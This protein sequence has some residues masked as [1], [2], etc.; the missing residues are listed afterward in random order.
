LPENRR[1]GAVVTEPTLATLSE[2]ERKALQRKTLRTLMVSQTMGSAGVSVAVS[3]GGR[4]VSQITGGSR[5]GGTS[6]AAVTFGG[7]LA[8]LALSGLM[9]QRGRRP[10]LTAGYILS[11]LGG[12]VVVLGIEQNSL[13]IF[14]FG[15]LF[16]GVGQGTNL[17]ARYAAADLTLPT[18]RAQAMSLLM[19]GS[20]FGA[21]LSLVLIE[22]LRTV[23][24]RVGLQ[25]FSGPYLFAVVLLIIALLNTGLRLY[26]DPLKVAGGVSPSAKRFQVPN[27]RHAVGVVRQSRLATLGLT[28][29]IVS[30]TAMVAVMTMTPIH[31]KEHGHDKVSSLV[32]ALHVVGMYGFAPI[33]GRMSDRWG[34]LQV[35]LAGAAVMVAATITSAAAG[36]RPSVLFIGLFLLG[37][38]WSGAMISGTALVT[39]NVPASEKVGVQGSADL[40]MS[41]SGGSAAFLS[42]LIKQALE[43]HY[44]S[45]LGTLG[46]AALLL[47]ALRTLRAHGTA[48]LAPLA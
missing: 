5:W 14:L 34:R 43:Y 2:P 23:A 44:L 7:A 27:V 12:L 15:S 11:L 41:L 1:Y 13:E 38:G 28:S 20:T 16:F 21:V 32:I 22:P 47:Y 36:A 25:E 3:V 40:L 26:P 24:K 19:F 6:S 17:L 10:G 31:M 33:V 4:F 46:T 8:G 18:E 9:R 29:M 39:D 45:I 30:Q 48:A 42:G 35:V 37:V